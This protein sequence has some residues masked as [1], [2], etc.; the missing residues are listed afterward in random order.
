[1][2]RL[3]TF[4][5]SR[6]PVRVWL[7]VLSASDATF[8]TLRPN[9]CRRGILAILPSMLTSPARGANAIVDTF[10]LGAATTSAGDAGAHPFLGL[11]GR[12]PSS[13][14]LRA[15]RRNGRGVESP[16]T[17]RMVDGL[18]QRV[19]KPSVI[20]LQGGRA[21][22]QT[23]ARGVCV[24]VVGERGPHAV[25]DDEAG[26]THTACSERAGRWAEERWPGARRRSDRCAPSSSRQS[27]DEGVA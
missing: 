8:A 4:A 3:Y 22:S 1:M 15:S 9:S 27:Q 20:V 11:R 26:H 25:S 5:R 16:K 18:Q 17:G 24:C 12:R 13:G 21:G 23:A 10:D 7:L 14:G 2:M 19:G 6:P